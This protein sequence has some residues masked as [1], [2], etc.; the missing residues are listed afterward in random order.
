[1][2]GC[3]VNLTFFRE[4]KTLSLTENNQFAGFFTASSRGT[5]AVIL[6]PHTLMNIIYIDANIY[7]GF[8]NS[9]RPEYKKLL[10]SIIELSDKIIFT[11]QIANEID[12]NKL[13]IFRQSMENYTRQ[14]SMTSTKLP[15]HLDEV[16]TA[17]L[18]DWNKQ[19]RELET[20]IEKL[21][22][23]LPSILNEILNDIALSKDKISQD[24]NVI[25]AKAMQP[26]EEE[27][28]KAQLRKEIG[29]PPGKRA[30][31][32]GDQL[33]WEQLLSVV[34]GA[35]SLWIISTDRDYFTEHKNTIYLNPILYK[36]LFAINPEIIIKPYNVLSEA[37]RDYNTEEEKINSIPQ[38]EELDQISKIESLD[39]SGTTSGATSS[40]IPLS[41]FFSPSPK[42]NFCPKCS[43]IDSFNDGAY[44]RSQYGGLTLQ[45]VCKNCGFDADTADYFD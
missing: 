19:R 16:G 25:Y 27:Y 24:L 32:L 22:K 7:L 11:Q 37:L 23:D 43:A 13:N 18:A 2:A 36:D 10:N 8:Y 28:R 1:M 6:N 34:P 42:P 41:T 26:T 21:N 15:E 5:L 17:K 4:E 44:L 31:P 38:K 29:N 40:Y 45:Y 3:V 9:N 35:K 33:S 30:D 20:H 14:V 12:R 39:L